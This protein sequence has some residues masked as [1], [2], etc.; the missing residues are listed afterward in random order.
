MLYQHGCQGLYRLYHSSNEPRR[1]DH[2]VKWP[3]R[4]LGD[5]QFASP[6]FVLCQTDRLAANTPKRMMG[7][8]C[9]YA[10]PSI[11]GEQ[12]VEWQF[13]GGFG[14]VSFTL[15]TNMCWFYNCGGVIFPHG[16]KR[17]KKSVR[18]PGRMRH[19]FRGHP[20]RGRLPGQLY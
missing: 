16:V 2:L 14:S 6:F 5:A 17:S 8:Y 13:L 15:E 20:R 4:F 3:M 1:S 18:G 11:N 10:D 12:I 19:L 9:F 7:N